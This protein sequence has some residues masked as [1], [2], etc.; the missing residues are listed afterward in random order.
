[1]GEKRLLWLSGLGKCVLRHSVPQLESSPFGRHCHDS[2][3]S[4]EGPCPGKGV[5]LR[6]AIDEVQC[7]HSIQ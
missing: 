6:L 2:E 7:Q 4:S 1:M 5:N 3:L